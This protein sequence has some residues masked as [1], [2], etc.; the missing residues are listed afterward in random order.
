MTISPSPFQYFNPANTDF[1]AL[2]VFREVNS[3]KKKATMVA[4]TI[5]EAIFELGFGG[6][7]LFR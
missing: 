4:L 6:V 2:E 1:R 3:F 7:A 5:L